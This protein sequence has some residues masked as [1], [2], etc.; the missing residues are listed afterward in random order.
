MPEETNEFIIKTK[1]QQEW[2]WFIAV[3][4]FL[5]GIG[6]GAYIMSVWLMHNVLA[7]FIGIAIVAV[8]S[9]LAFFLDLS[10]KSQFWRVMM[11]PQRSWISRG[12]LLIILF[13][14]SGVVSLIAP[15]PVLQ[16]V[17]TICAVGVMMYS[18]FVLSYSPA[19]PFWNTP[20]LPLISIVY[21]LMG[22]VGLLF[23]LSAVGP[24]LET[25]ETL[26]MGLIAICAILIFTYLITMSS[27]TIAAR[28]ATSSL[29]AGRQAAPFWVLVVLAGLLVPFIF[30]SLTKFGVLT[31]QTL[32]VAG[33]L[34]L[35]G[36]LSFRY[37][38]LRAGRRL[39]VV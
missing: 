29:I 16:W 37:C 22:G 21:A 35:T 25:L 17:A 7:G 14:I 32:V 19:I 6:S 23:G 30:A 38:L 12:I 13:T 24:G 11:R 36:A 26:E 18:G 10:R 5:A 20:L 28:E 34:E 39:A 8:G 4:L 15:N 31:S 2:R 27:S 3:A 33:V 1:T 9:S